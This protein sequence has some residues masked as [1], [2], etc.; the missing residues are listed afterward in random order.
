MTKL[1]IYKLL[2]VFGQAEGFFFLIMV[3]GVAEELGKD[4]GKEFGTEQYRADSCL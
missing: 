1:I 4:V 3:W 2:V